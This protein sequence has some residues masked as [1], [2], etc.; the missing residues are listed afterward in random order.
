MLRAADGTPLMTIVA[1]EVGTT[2][3]SAGRARRSRTHCATGTTPCTSTLCGELPRRRRAWGLGK[4]D[5]VR[6]INFYMNV[7]VE[8]DGTLGIVDGLSAPGE[9]LTLRAESDTL[10]LVSNCPQINNPCNGFDPTAGP[11]DRHGSWARN[12]AQS[13]WSGPGML[14]TVQDWPGRV[15]YWHVGVPPSGPMDDLSFRLGN[16][17]VGNPRG[18]RR[19]GVHE[20]RS[21]TA[22]SPT[23]ARGVRH[24][25]GSGRDAGRRAGAAVAVGHRCGRRVLDVGMLTGPGMRGYVLV[26]GGLHEAEYLGSTRDIHA[27][28]VRRSRGAATARRRPAD[29][30]APSGPLNAPSVPE[31]PSTSSP[32]SG[33]AGSSR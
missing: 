11:D 32:A 23:G 10:V 29:R 4:R 15:G 3:P 28:R 7:P 25:R 16:R 1:D 22:R 30:Q 9:S 19:A 26:A 13:R 14:T 17:V 6:N 12:E 21:G 31:R 20:R 33:S 24:R 5:I 27:R 8:A 2:T 18:H